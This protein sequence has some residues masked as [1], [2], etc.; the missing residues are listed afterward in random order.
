MG[1]PVRSDSSE[2]LATAPVPSTGL[3]TREQNARVVKSAFDK[4][5]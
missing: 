2:M 5:P 1:P 3:G 4:N